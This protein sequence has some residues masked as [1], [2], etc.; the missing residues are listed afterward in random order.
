MTRRIA[1]VGAGGF[2]RELRWLI[3]EI[4]GDPTPFEFCGYVVTDMAR[5]GAD[6]RDVVGD[7][8]WIE[9]NVATLDC[10]AIGIGDPEAR[11]RIAHEL[12]AAFP[13]IDWPILIHPSVRIDRQSSTLGRGVV[14]CAGTIGTVNVQIDDFAMV[15]LACTIGH[16][17]RIGQGCVLNPTVNVSGGV[18]LGDAVLVGTGAQLLQNLTIGAGATVGAGAVV[19]KDVAPDATVV[20]MPAKPLRQSS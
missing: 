17:A 11:L 5:P 9:H 20:G 14:L 1:V 10:L 12:S 7:Y 19:T 2:A 13:T 16:E 8:S 18:T 6:G 15:N 3:S 4:E